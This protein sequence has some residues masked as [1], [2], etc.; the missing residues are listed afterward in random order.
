M[1]TKATLL[2]LALAGTFSLANAQ[3]ITGDVKAGEKKNA[4]CIGCH[5]IPGY[6]SSFP[7]VHNVPMISGQN[8]KYIAAALEGYRKGERKH[9]S[10]RGVAGSLTDQDIADLSAFY[11]SHGKV[12]NAPAV[13]AQADLPAAIKDKLAA[14]TACHGVNFNNTTDP[15]NPRLAGQHADYLAVALK[16]YQTGGSSVVGRGNATM[17]AMAKPLTDAEIKQIAA[18][19]GGLPGELKTI[20]QSKF[21]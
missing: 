17:V 3:A 1:K 16:A 18:F 10:M 20:P 9:P 5:G 7:Q 15:A 6:R 11:E 13:P 2:L 4:M 21:R 19:L 12:V 14:C 8:A